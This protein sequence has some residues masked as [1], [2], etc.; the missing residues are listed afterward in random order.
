VSEEGKGTVG[1]KK[2]HQMKTIMGQALG[3]PLKKAHTTPVNG[4]ADTERAYQGLVRGNGPV[5]ERTTAAKEGGY[6]SPAL[7]GPQG[8]RKPK[9][10]VP[11]SCS[12]RG[13]ESEVEN[14]S[15]PMGGGGKTYT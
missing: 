12:G 5:G 11:R 4:E 14:S 15:S 9:V 10:K 13:G 1:K 2:W 7:W 3:R 6:L 8:L